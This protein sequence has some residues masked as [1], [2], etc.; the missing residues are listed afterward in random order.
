MTDTPQ[1]TPASFW[2][3]MPLTR[4][5]PIMIAVPTILLAMAMSGFS[6]WQASTAL[7]E[8]RHMIFED[9][10]SSRED[11]L[12][13]WINEVNV[14]ITALASELSVRE[15]VQSMT[16]A[17]DAVDASTGDAGAYLRKTYVDENPNPVGSRDLLDDA[18]DRTPWSGLHSRFHEA[19]RTVQQKRGY[20]DLF[21]FD[22]RGN[23]IYSV[24][25]EVDFATNVIDG[26]YA[27]SGLGAVFREALTLK[28][29]QQALSSYAAY[30]PSKGAPA[31]FAA[32]PVFDKTGTLVGVVALQIG[33]DAVTNILKASNALG[34]TG[35]I[36]AFNDSGLA[37]SASRFEGGHV[38][39]QS[40]KS[41]PLVKAALE[42]VELDEMRA[43]GL[44]GHPVEAWS[45]SFDLDGFRW[46][47]IFEQD[48]AEVLRVENALLLTTLGQVAVQLLVVVAVAFLIAR[49]LTRRISA[50]QGSVQRVAGGDYRTEVAEVRTEDEI[51]QIARAFN[52]FKRQLAEGEEAR[53]ERDRATR[54]QEHVMEVLGQGLNA[55]SSGQL[56]CQIEE[57][58][59]AQYERLRV[60]FNDTV[61]ALTLVIDEL[62][63][64]AESI[65]VDAQVLSEGAD[66]L[67]ARTENQAATLEETAA[68]MEEIT[69]SVQSTAGGA[70]EIVSAI[71]SARKQAEHGEQVRNRAVDA[72]GA[73]EASSKQISQIIQVMEDIA[74]QTNLLALNAGVEAARA[75]EV[76]RGFAV[77][78]SEVRALAQRSSDSAAEIRNLIVNSNESV[79]NGVRLVSDMGASIERILNEVVQVSGRVNDIAAGASEQATGLSEI[80]NGITMLDQV[81][82]QNAAM[83]G[84]SA[85]AGR[86]LQSKA[87]DLRSLVARFGDGGPA[88]RRAPAVK[89]PEPSVHADTSDLGWD[90]L[91]PVT[92][93][94]DETP[95]A[96]A[97]GTAG[98][99]LKIAGAA[100]PGSVDLWDEF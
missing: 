20:Y 12:R 51:G 76:G 22:T 14:D 47:L 62:R 61:D 58:L 95:P 16:R 18:G 37:L 45:R 100:R 71:A 55:L 2:A 26:P 54:H 98:P 86:A 64:S 11:A 94:L 93:P 97:T 85:A 78:A 39:L 79:S 5:L 46:H 48:E 34:E 60:N 38:I 33:I 8:R 1:K 90:A 81:T 17:W 57:N 87:A 56:S 29:G 49:V 15:A 82:Q 65:D 30:A 74:F 42:G 80:N 6:F 25:K 69:K 88:K 36:N 40:L 63:A 59:G 96:R 50:L 68:A 35:Q 13:T 75:G 28:D 67:S 43:T 91:D 89:A 84:E 83:V 21:L 70:K 4:K 31:R 41:N 9:V 27:D 77:V 73:I 23:V 32:A 19:F 53:A 44:N 3:R 10:L 52:R 92:I 66:N 99:R 72:M 7:S 24:F